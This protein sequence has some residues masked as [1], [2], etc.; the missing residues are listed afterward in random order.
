[1]TPRPGSRPH[2]VIGD[3]YAV[4]RGPITDT[5]FHQHAAFQITTA[6]R[7]DVVLVAESGPRHQSGTRH[8]PEEQRGP[9][10]RGESEAQHRCGTLIV[11]PWVRHRMLATPEMT[12]FFVDPHCAFADRIRRRCGSGI[13][14]APELRDLSE[15]HLRTTG[16]TAST[17][18]DPRLAEA[19]DALRDRSVPMPA[20][21][22]MV[23]LSPQ[24]LRALARD[25]VGMP[26]SRWRSWERLRRAAA[27]LQ[28]GESLA[29]AALAAGFADQ[30]HL[31]RQMREMVG[32]TPAAVLPALRD[33]ARCATWTESDPVGVDTTSD[34]RTS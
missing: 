33:H 25:Q 26:L 6:V 8:Q 1:M 15:G 27:V 19:L 12:T 3:G 24:R 34:S 29:A 23:G 10:T 14:A 28:D 17:Q 13:T 9:E 16:A 18:L 30:A 11:P 32:L 4:Y 20:L 21:A 2:I 7:G 5:A 22:A 31:T